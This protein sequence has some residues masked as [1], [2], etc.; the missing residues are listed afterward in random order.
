M[1]YLIATLASLLAFTSGLLLMDNQSRQS[2]FQLLLATAFLIGSLG[3]VVFWAPQSSCDVPAVFA[4]TEPQAEEVFVPLVAKDYNCSP[5]ASGVVS[6]LSHG[7]DCTEALGKPDGHSVLLN[8]RGPYLPADQ[9]TFRL[10]PAYV[11][12]SLRLH[13]YNTDEGR[14]EVNLYDRAQALVSTLST[15]VL[16]GKHV[17]VLESTPWNYIRIR[18]ISGDG[19]NLDAIVSDTGVCQ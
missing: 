2:L 18:A 12:T 14:V 11:G 6:C 4:Q 1:I 19:I 5:F 16:V 10:D 15:D 8:T 17:I 7:S 3:V 9:A 13:T